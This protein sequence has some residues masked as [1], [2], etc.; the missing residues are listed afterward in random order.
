MLLM[1]SVKNSV[2]ESDF[3]V[4]RGKSEGNI[5][6]LSINKHCFTKKHKDFVLLL[7]VNIKFITFLT[8]DVA[9]DRAQ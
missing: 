3:S 5:L 1:P 4:I 2:S 9:F 8:F 7:E 6:L